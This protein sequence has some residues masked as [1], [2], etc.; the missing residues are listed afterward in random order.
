[1]DLTILHDGLWKP[2]T[3]TVNRSVLT[4]TYEASNMALK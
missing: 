1:M 4:I 2:K 3:I